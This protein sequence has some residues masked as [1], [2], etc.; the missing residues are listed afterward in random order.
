MVNAP[1]QSY[2]EFMYG[3]ETAEW[4]LAVVF[5]AMFALFVLGIGWGIWAIRGRKGEGDLEIT[6]P[7]HHRRA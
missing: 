2:R 7:G 1:E 3:S 4:V 5:I 6:K